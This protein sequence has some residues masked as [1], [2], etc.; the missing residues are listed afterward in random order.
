MIAASV[1]HVSLC[2]GDLE[3]SLGF[4]RD[5]LG[6][7]PLERPDFGF[8]GAW[9]DAGGTQ[10]HLIVAPEGI[11]GLG[12][13]PEKLNPLANHLA[14]R[15]ED[16]AATRERLQTAGLEVLGDGSRGQMWVQD[17]SGHIVEFIEP[18]SAGDPN[19]R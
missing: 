14:F 1:H 2:V 6:L 13:P 15:I 8:P 17:P 3:A 19:E 4:Y 5:L 18:R 9:L 7:V 10:L 11:P 12:T 16:L